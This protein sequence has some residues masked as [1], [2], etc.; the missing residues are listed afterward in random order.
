[1]N[2]DSGEDNF[3]FSVGVS[4]IEICFKGFLG[5]GAGFC[6]WKGENGFA[7]FTN[8]AFGDW[9][10]SQFFRKVIFQSRGKQFSVINV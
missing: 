9:N 6:V 3:L 2:F 8:G 7:L 1:M 5:F 10:T 4:Y